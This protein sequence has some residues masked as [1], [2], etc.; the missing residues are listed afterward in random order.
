[1]RLVI[2]RKIK[3]VLYFRRLLS[4]HIGVVLCWN[5]LFCSVVEN[6]IMNGCINWKR[7]FCNPD[8]LSCRTSNPIIFPSLLGTEPYNRPR[9]LDH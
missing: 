9:L 8:I 1:M 4:P 5:L 3:R 7:T 6:K 2:Q